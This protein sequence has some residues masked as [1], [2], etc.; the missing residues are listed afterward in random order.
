[1]TKYSYNR[2]S[3]VHP[4]ICWPKLWTEDFEL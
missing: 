2:C 3:A 4:I 1:M